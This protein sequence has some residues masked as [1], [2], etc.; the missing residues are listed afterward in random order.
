[1]LTLTINQPHLNLFFTSI[2]LEYHIEAEYYFRSKFFLLLAG[3]PPPVHEFAL[4]ASKGLSRQ[5]VSTA[6]RVLLWNRLN[7]GG[8]SGRDAAPQPP[9]PHHRRIAEKLLAV[10][11]GA[12]ATATGEPCSTVERE[13]GTLT[14]PPP[15]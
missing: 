6:P 10:G 3:R 11:A 5:R 14:L 2:S 1:M 15:V 7:V 8:A 12:R 9:P 13:R 4:A